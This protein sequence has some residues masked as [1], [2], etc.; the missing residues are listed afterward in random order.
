[1]ARAIAAWSLA[2]ASANL[3]FNVG[4]PEPVTVSDL[5][6]MIYTYGQEMGLL[7]TNTSL[8]FSRI[9]APEHDV[10]Y[11]VPSITRVQDV[12]GWAPTLSVAESVR[13]CVSARA[14]R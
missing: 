5:A 3:A 4:N 8:R 2:P 7:P 1:V 11:R 6:Q 9:D 10:R 14:G 13:R 12:F